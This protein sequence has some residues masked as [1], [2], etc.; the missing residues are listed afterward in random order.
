MKT[1]TFC[2][3]GT[4]SIAETDR[5]RVRLYKAFFAFWVVIEREMC[6]NTFATTFTKINR[7]YFSPEGTLLLKSVHSCF[8]YLW[9]I[10]LCYE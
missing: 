3:H 2:G 4:L 10:C 5:L 8:A 6:Y 9:A 1:V 7:Q